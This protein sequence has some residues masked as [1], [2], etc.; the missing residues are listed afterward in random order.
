VALWRDFA[1]IA[2]FFSEISQNFGF[3]KF[4]IFSRNFTI[5]TGFS[6]FSRKFSTE[7]IRENAYVFREIVSVIYFTQAFSTGFFG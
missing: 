7:I 5:L 3:G 1:K 2:N 4:R 6:T